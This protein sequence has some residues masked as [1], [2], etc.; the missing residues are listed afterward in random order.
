MLEE[1]RGKLTQVTGRLI[2]SF[3]TFD[4]S[5]VLH[6]QAC[7]AALYYLKRQGKLSDKVNLFLVRTAKQRDELCAENGIH[8]EHLTKSM[9]LIRQLD[10]RTINDMTEELASLPEAL[11]WGVRY[12]FEPELHLKDIPM[13]G[14]LAVTLD[15]VDED[16]K[17]VLL[18]SQST[19]RTLAATERMMSDDA[20][21]KK[22]DKEKVLRGVLYDYVDQRNYAR[23]YIQHSAGEPDFLIAAK[24][25]NHLTELIE[26]VLL[27]EP[28][29]KNNRLI[30]DIVWAL[31]SLLVRQL[32]RCAKRLLSGAHPSIGQEL[33]LLA[34][35]LV[36]Q[37][38][39][40]EGGVLGIPEM[41]IMLIE[42]NLRRFYKS[43][44]DAKLLN[45]REVTDFRKLTRMRLLLMKE[46]MLSSANA[47][48]ESARV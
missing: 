9:E 3:V 47:N 44:E 5:Y 17:N 37:Q 31:R 19:E 15:L 13:I 35:D 30:M 18:A 41:A 26:A 27:I 7:L 43:L 45:A 24:A 22:I 25:L 48:A 12:V 11:A 34:Q 1:T 29:L 38:R 21:D 32:H 23:S 36:M 20:L 14:L 46:T 28:Q 2:E 8:P 40:D 4:K 39:R 33:Q 6:F 16:L 42:K 10:G